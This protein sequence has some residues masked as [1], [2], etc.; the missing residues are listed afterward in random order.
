MAFETLDIAA[1][2]IPFERFAL[3]E[4]VISIVSRKLIND[5]NEECIRRIVRIK[6][7]TGFVREDKFLLNS[8]FKHGVQKDS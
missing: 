4:S 8:D 6:V 5:P 2:G 3:K 7:A 1:L